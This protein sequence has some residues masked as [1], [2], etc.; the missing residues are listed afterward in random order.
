MTVLGTIKDGIPQL[1]AKDLKT[2]WF[3]NQ[4]PVPD[5]LAA[6]ILKQLPKDD[7]QALNNPP[8]NSGGTPWPS[9]NAGAG[10]VEPVFW[11]AKALSSR[12]ATA[13]L[14]MAPRTG[15]AV[16]TAANALQRSRFQHTTPRRHMENQHDTLLGL[17]WSDWFEHR[18]E[19][20]PTEA[21]AR[22]AAVDRG[23][24]LLVDPTGSF[25]A[26][27]AGGCSH[28][29]LAHE[30]PCVGDWVHVERQPDNDFGTI[31][32]ILER[33]TVLRRKSVG[34]VVE[35]QMIAANVDCVV[36]VQSCQF[37]FNLKRLE[38][39]LVMVKDG[40][41]TVHPADQDRPGGACCSG[42]AV[43]GHTGCRHHRA[44]ADLEQRDA[45]GRGCV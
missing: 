19:Y 13:A 11:V 42:R 34:N 18:A 10:G 20:R 21:I 23:Q 12:A 31:H 5:V 8:E 2:S 26:K 36:I 4:A 3:D 24:Y 45:R 17:G 44:G 41:R 37:D 33:K 14:D 25:R 9:A 6:N 30:L 28:R 22:V 16:E 27:L 40:G 7:D 43:G 15:T 1:G 39:Y 35:Y 29:R 32:T 38:R